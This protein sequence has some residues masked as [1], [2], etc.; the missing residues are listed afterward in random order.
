MYCSVI[1]IY[2]NVLLLCTEREFWW[3]LIICY[4]H[5]LLLFL[6]R[7]NYGT[8]WLMLLCF[9][10]QVYSVDCCLINKQVYF[11]YFLCSVI[12]DMCSVLSTTSNFTSAKGSAI[13]LVHHC[14]LPLFYDC[15]L[16]KNSYPRIILH[17]WI[18]YVT[19]AIWNIYI[20]EWNSM[21]WVN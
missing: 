19:L 16:S 20:F 18:C 14:I 3:C 6:C 9:N 2:L 1:G 17:I 21:N 8:N 5:A 13:S 7:V 12:Y 11:V 4:C 15:Q 10:K